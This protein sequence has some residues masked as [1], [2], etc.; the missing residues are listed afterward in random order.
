MRLFEEE[1]V[2]KGAR[3]RVSDLNDVH[4]RL[5]S[6]ALWNKQ[7]ALFVDAALTITSYLTLIGESEIACFEER[8]SPFCVDNRRE[9][10]IL[11]WRDID[12]LQHL[13]DAAVVHHDR[14]GLLL[15]WILCRRL[16]LLCLDGRGKDGWEEN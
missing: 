1:A 14:D 10:G 5:G 2:V 11:D 3:D 15:R 13:R 16:R 6:S 7:P 12:A 9:R 8:P 4:L